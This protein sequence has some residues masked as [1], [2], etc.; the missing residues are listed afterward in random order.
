[1]GQS[2]CLCW[3][4]LPRT[5]PQPRS[6]VDGI[7]V[8]HTWISVSL[9]PQELSLFCSKKTK[10]NAYIVYDRVTL[11]FSKNWQ[12]IVNQLWFLKYFFWKKALLPVAHH[13]EWG[14]YSSLFFI[15]SWGRGRAWTQSAQSGTSSQTIPLKV[16]T[17]ST[18]EAERGKSLPPYSDFL[19]TPAGAF[20]KELGL[21]VI[22]VNHFC[23]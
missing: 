16:A 23:I 14:G 18:S 17:D 6:Q 8:P 5:K 9:G 21:S 7:P 15:S 2:S 22:L 20:P 3:H 10:M 19:H 13:S 11:L 4:P 12:F 1:M